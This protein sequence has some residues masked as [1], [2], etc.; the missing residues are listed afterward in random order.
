M[1]DPDHGSMLSSALE[2]G[3]RKIAMNVITPV[4]MGLAGMRRC[5]QRVKRK[6]T[7]RGFVRQFSLPGPV[8]L[9]IMDPIRDAIRKQ[10]LIYILD[11]KRRLFAA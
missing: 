2:D 4:M 11:C 6:G 8:G 3:A 5:M 9:I 1:L 10:I 7:R